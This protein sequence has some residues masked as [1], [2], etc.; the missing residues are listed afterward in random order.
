MNAGRKVGHLPTGEILRSNVNE[1]LQLRGF[2]HFDITET[3]LRK[4][5]LGSAT[6]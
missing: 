4:A 1:P 6:L 2:P 3:L 5:D